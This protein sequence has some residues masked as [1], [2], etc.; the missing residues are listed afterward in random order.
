MTPDNEHTTQPDFSEK[1]SRP[2]TVLIMGGSGV[3]GGAICQRF[4]EAQWKVGIHY[5]RNE[6][7]ARKLCQEI[8]K[9]GKESSLF[10]ADVRNQHQTTHLLKQFLHRWERLDALIW[11]VG[12]AISTLTVRISPEEWDELIQTNLT[13]L[14]FCLQSI[15]P[16]LQ[17]QK[18][19]SFLVISSLASMKGATGQ[20]AYAASKAGVL[21]LVRSV[22]QEWGTDNIRV[23]AV[24]PGWHRS[25]LTGEAF[26]PPEACHDHLLG[27]TPNLQETA[28]HIYHLATA[29]DIS[30]QIFNLD[31]R[32]W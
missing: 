1:K 8:Q 25:A 14:F 7:S 27:R 23:N 29:N 32:I 4:A 17:A 13:S 15:G 18:S 21:G 26:P 31:S 22:A 19:G 28:D 30:G 11:A 20:A 12:H 2:R 10:Q 3:I 16:L 24:F 9:Q 6:T 5:Y